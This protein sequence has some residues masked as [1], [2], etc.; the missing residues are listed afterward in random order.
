MPDY[1]LIRRFD[2][3]REELSSFDAPLGS[4][5]EVGRQITLD[6]EQWTIV[7]ATPSQDGLP[8]TLVVSRH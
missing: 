5:I 1:R 7:E 3:G 2:D 4:G 6:G 8:P